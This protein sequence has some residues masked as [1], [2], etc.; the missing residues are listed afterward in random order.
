M[1]DEKVFFFIDDRS[2]DLDKPAEMVKD[3]YYGRF[4]ERGFAP[5]ILSELCAMDMLYAVTNMRDGYY[6]ERLVL[7]GGLSVRSAVPLASH[8]FSFDADFDPNTPGGFSYRDVSGLKGDIEKYGA[9]RG[10]KTRVS[11]TRDE[12]RL[13]FVEAEYRQS[14]DEIHHIIERPKIEVC[15]TCRVH[16]TPVLSRINTIIDLELLGLEPPVVAHLSLEEQFAAK[17]HVI[18][19]NTRQRKHFDA[20]DSFRMFQSNKIDMK[21]ARELFEKRCANYVPGP[22]AYAEEC[23]RCLDAMLGDGKK[24]TK[25]EEATFAGGFDFDAMVNEVKSF[26]GFPR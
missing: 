2:V 5:F 10:C 14:L 26:Y 1:M 9:A 7:K 8:R 20:Y 3:E 15:K 4:A 6:R 21:K 13:H 18:G 22:G 17:L 12:Q 25:L 19:S 16:E 24:R 11:V 23:R